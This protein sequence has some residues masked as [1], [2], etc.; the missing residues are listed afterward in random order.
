[1]GDFRSGQYLN[2]R[3]GRHELAIWAAVVKSVLP[4][5]EISLS[6]DGSSSV[7]TH[8]Q[9]VPIVDL[10]AKLNLRG[11]I[12]GRLPSIVVTDTG[13]GLAAFLADGISEIVHARARDFRAGKLRIGRPRQIVDLAVLRENPV[14]SL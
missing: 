4:A 5:H 2:F 12:V 3:V 6:D 13:S 10:Q 14:N 11:G 9:I 1:V 7:K 8:G